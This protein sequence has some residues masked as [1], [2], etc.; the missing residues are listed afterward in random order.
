MLTAVRAFITHAV[1][2]GQAPA[3]V[4]AL[5][6]GLADARDLPAQ[7]A[8]RT[9][10]GRGGSQVYVVPTESG[11]WFTRARIRA[12]ASF[13]PGRSASWYRMAGFRTMTVERERSVF[14]TTTAP[15]L[16]AA[17]G[18][19]QP[20][21]QGG[22]ARFAFFADDER[23]VVVAGSQEGHH[24]DLAFALGLS[25]RADRQLVLVLPEQH[26]FATLQRGPWFTGGA[27]PQVY[28][29]NGATLRACPLPVQSETVERLT[30]VK[31]GLSP[32]EELRLAATPKHLGS[33]S[34]AVYELSEWA[35]KHPLLDASHRRGER[36]WHCMGQKVLS[37]KAT[38]GG[39]AVTA[40]IHYS[41][42]GQA[43]E[44]QIIGPGET[45]TRSQFESVKAQVYEGAEARLSG[46]PPIHRPDE[47]WLQAV[48]R[49]DPSMVGVEQ[50]A[51]REVPAWRPEGDGVTTSWGRGYIDL[52]G[53][54][55]HAD[56]R[57]VETKLADNPD[58]LLVFQ[59][60]D[61]YIWAQA[62]RRVLV[63]RLGAPEGAAFEIHYVIG[64]TPDGDIHISKHAGAQVHGLDPR[65]RWRFQT[66]RN[67]HGDPRESARATS[68][69]LGPGEL[70]DK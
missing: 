53:V 9:A 46:P 44:P 18:V 5:A 28:L 50:P 7:P 15:K 2:T 22:S 30:S 43:P 57:I 66:I 67:W 62:S 51:L 16:A 60:L 52:L 61:Y 13:P 20:W 45:L 10:G 23:F 58:D 69:L 47:H 27:R 65:V 38:K 35:T 31:P 33:H 6:Y 55:G 11:G 37:I 17:V 36:S 26:A 56:M 3:E 21:D 64:A 8:A 70:P 34:G 49:R 42:Q 12:S 59:G 14:N 40:G 68:D 4:V 19:A 25:Y 24:V 63:D 41:K 32:E 1:T 48:I 39:L 54:D 29:H